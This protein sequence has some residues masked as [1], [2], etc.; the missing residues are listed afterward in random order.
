MA[1]VTVT[2]ALTAFFNQEP[3]KV[4]A[5]EW[6]NELKAFESDDEK[7]KLAQEVCDFTGDTLAP[8]VAK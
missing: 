2:K 8:P 1:Q 4:P 6:L 7:R 5:K 3:R